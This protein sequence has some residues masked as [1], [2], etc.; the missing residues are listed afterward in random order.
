MSMNHR[1]NQTDPGERDSTN[2]RLEGRSSV[3]ND[4]PDSERDRKELEN[5]E[6]FINLPD[7]KD[8]PGQEFINVPPAGRYADT[9]ISSD[10]EEGIGVFDKDDSEDITMGTSA[11]VSNDERTALAD[12]TY[13]PTTDEDNLRKASMDD[14][15]FQ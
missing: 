14:R 13:M 5:E 6:T 15:D 4:L 11:D 8:I 9:T 2:N 1:S 12:T 7:V 10:D 3:P